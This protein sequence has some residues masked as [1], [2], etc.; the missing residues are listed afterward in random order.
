MELRLSQSYVGQQIVRFASRIDEEAQQIF[1]LS[2]DNGPHR[3][4]SQVA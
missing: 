3:N 4:R 2:A 1:G